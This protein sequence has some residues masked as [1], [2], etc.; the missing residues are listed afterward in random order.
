MFGEVEYQRRQIWREKFPNV[1][2]SLLSIFEMI[3]TFAVIGCEIPTIFFHFP[4]MNAFVGY[5]A[6]LFFMCA[7][8]SLA[9]ISVVLYLFTKYSSIFTGN[10]L[11]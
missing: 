8:I 1:I 4:R 6:F 3:L 9:G 7:W 2:G 5:W 11:P 10:H